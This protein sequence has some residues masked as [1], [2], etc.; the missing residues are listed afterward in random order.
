MS[1]LFTLSLVRNN[2]IREAY[3]LDGFF[4]EADLLSSLYKKTQIKD[5][6]YVVDIL[7]YIGYDKKTVI[8][9]SLVNYLLANNQFQMRCGTF[10]IVDKK[11][12]KYYLNICNLIQ[13]L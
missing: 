2:K 7:P 13:K 1:Y 4:C 6:F 11:R 8:G 9:M 3:F 5:Y 10:R 12:I